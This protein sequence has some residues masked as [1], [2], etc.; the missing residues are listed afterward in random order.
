[1]AHLD[2]SST[3]E[4]SRLGPPS[5]NETALTWTHPL[6]VARNWIPESLLPLFGS[7]DYTQL[8]PRQRRTYNY[9]YG[10]QLLEEFVWIES[11]LIVAPLTAL[12]RDMT[13]DAPG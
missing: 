8:S 11:R 4:A 12:R 2:N 10:A 3:R 13:G 1:M 6:D 5:L 7:T 9:A